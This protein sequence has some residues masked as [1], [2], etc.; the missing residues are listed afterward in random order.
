MHLKIVSERLKEIRRVLYKNQVKEKI[1]A[2]ILISKYSEAKKYSLKH[3][4]S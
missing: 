4:N 2:A 1:F 3:T